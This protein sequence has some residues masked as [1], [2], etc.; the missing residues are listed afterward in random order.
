MAADINLVQLI[1]EDTGF[2]DQLG[3]LPN[4]GD[5]WY[6]FWTTVQLLA[7]GII[8]GLGSEPLHHLIT[9]LERKRE[10][11]ARRE[12]AVIEAQKKPL[13]T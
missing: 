10:K 8:I 7:S 13:T 11:R 1:L 6:G 12:K 3:F 5:P 4:V 9:N 2:Q